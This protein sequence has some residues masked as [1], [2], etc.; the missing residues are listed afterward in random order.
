MIKKKRLTRYVCLTACSWQI[1]VSLSSCSSRTT[2]AFS[3]CWS[4]ISIST[5]T[6]STYATATRRQKKSRTGKAICYM[7]RL[8][9]ISNNNSITGPGAVA[10]TEKQLLSGCCDTLDCSF[11]SVTSIYTQ[12]VEYNN[13]SGCGQTY[14]MSVFCQIDW[15][16]LLELRPDSFLLLLNVALPAELH[17][18]TLH[19]N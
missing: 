14:T 13:I 12:Q 10:Y 1:C 9:Y 4:S 5:F 19:L 15:T 8:I 18:V 6:C 16:A 2:L 3:Y 17:Y 11:Q 7:S